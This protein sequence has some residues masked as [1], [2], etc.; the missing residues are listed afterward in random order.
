MQIHTDAL[1][2]GLKRVGKAEC[3]KPQTFFACKDFSANDRL[4]VGLFVGAQGIEIRRQHV[5][6]NAHLLKMTLVVEIFLFR[7]TIQRSNDFTQNLHADTDAAA[8]FVVN[9]RRTYRAREKETGILKG[10][11]RQ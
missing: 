7:R 3:A 10:I 4:L 5:G 1:A 9:N 8:K 6:Q 2:F 11:S